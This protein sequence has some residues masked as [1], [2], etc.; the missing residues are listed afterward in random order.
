MLHIRPGPEQAWQ[1][2]EITGTRS[3]KSLAGAG[4]GNSYNKGNV[5]AGSIYGGGTGADKNG[6]KV[7][8]P[9]GSY[10]SKSRQ[11]TAGTYSAAA[12]KSSVY[13]Q[14]PVKKKK[15]SLLGWL[16]VLVIICASLP[17]IRDSLKDSLAPI[18][19]EEFGDMFSSGADSASYKLMAGDVLEVGENVDGGIVPGYYIASCSN[20]FVSFMIMG[21][22]GENGS[23]TV[24]DGVERKITLKEGDLIGIINTE[25][26][27]SALMLTAR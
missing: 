3:S 7:S 13:T 15:G 16:M 20:G 27:D 2:P 4:T 8:V 21:E 6:N 26:E 22:E 1:G 12:K 5:K 14:K 25:S 17:E 10:N 9:A 18:L 23:M 19:E 24:T 11:S